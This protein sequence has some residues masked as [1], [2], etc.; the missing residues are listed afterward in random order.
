VKEVILCTGVD[1]T[2]LKRSVWSKLAWIVP[3][4]RPYGCLQLGAVTA[5]LAFP[6]ESCR[7]TPSWL[8]PMK[9]ADIQGVQIVLS[10][11]YFA[12]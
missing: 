12:S 7:H 8:S 4:V 11:A 1:H 3:S 5:Q 2:H 10:H 9:A 6:D